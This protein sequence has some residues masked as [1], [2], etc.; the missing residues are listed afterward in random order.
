MGSTTLLSRQMESEIFHV[1]KEAV[2]VLDMNDDRALAWRSLSFAGV[3][4]FCSQASDEAEPLQI[5]PRC[6]GRGDRYRYVVTVCSS[7]QFRAS[8]NSG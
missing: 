6:A 1:G 3:S 4:D 7:H 8:R 5:E 2:M